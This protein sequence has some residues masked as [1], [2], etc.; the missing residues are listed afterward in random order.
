MLTPSKA[1]CPV[2][3]NSVPRAWPATVALL[4]VLV[5]QYAWFE[6]H[7]AQPV[8]YD[9]QTYCQLARQL[10]FPLGLPSLGDGGF[11]SYGYPLLL[12]PFVGTASESRAAK[13]IYRFQFVLLAAL[14]VTLRLWLLPRRPLADSVLAIVIL[15]LPVLVP[16]CLV[17][18]SDLTG[19]VVLQFALL[20]LVWSQVAGRVPARLALLAL[21]GLLLGYAVQIRP[22]YYHLTWPALLFVA[23]TSR[24]RVVSSSMATK[25][26]AVIVA[27][28]VFTAGALVAGLPTV[29]DNARAGKPLRPIP[30]VGPLVSYHMMLGLWLDR[31][32]SNPPPIQEKLQAAEDWAQR[33]WSLASPEPGTSPTSGDYLKEIR[34]RPGHVCRQWLVHVYYAFEKWE[35]FPYQGTPA[36]WWSWQ[37]WL[38]NWLFLAAFLVEGVLSLCRP[39]AVVSNSCNRARCHFAAWQLVLFVYLILTTAPI[40]PEDRYSLALYP[41]V[42][43][44]VA[45]LACRVMTKGVQK[46]GLSG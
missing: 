12:K 42:L 7:F 40:V 20:V 18:L 16:Y 26:A 22:G 27:C 1:P 4:V 30:D 24:Q 44:F 43:V 34:Q 2:K 37:I 45:S 35:L 23:W 11:R 13:R 46:H 38:T 6:R 14:L 17:V 41:S 29:L 15:L 5:V 19:T 21:S 3:A 36:T 31:W 9:A 28:F 10:S 33:G 8:V 32:S 39:P 25:M